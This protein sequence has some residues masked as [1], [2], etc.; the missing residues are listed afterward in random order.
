MTVRELYNCALVA[1]V[2]DEQICATAFLKDKLIDSIKFLPKDFLGAEWKQ[3]TP[4]M[5]GY[6]ELVFQEDY[7]E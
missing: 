1:G 4:S 6:V 5:Q 3:S 7:H 2:Q